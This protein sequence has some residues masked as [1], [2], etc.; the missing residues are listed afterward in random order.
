MGQL[1]WPS[2]CKIR[3]LRMVCDA[4]KPISNILNGLPDLETLTLNEESEGINRTSHVIEV[5]SALYPRLTS[6]TISYKH[7]ILNL[8][9]ARLLFSHA[10]SLVYLKITGADKSLIDRSQWEKLIKT[11]LPHLKRFDFQRISRANSPATLETVL[12]QEIASF[13]TPFWIE[14]KRWLVICTWHSSSRSIEIYTPL[15]SSPDYLPFQ[16]LRAMTTTNFA[17][18]DQ[19]YTECLSIQH[20]QIDGDLSPNVGELSV[21]FDHWNLSGWW[22]DIDRS[23]VSAQT[24]SQHWFT[25]VHSSINWLHEHTIGQTNL[26]HSRPFC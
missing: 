23:E 8:N 11:K 7:H 21:A 19:Y 13:R 14:E 15:V 6:L 10:L 1:K 12:N 25:G 9:R 16:H 2:Q 5:F 22:D 17:G 18:Q 26:P 4:G 3:H 20:R 24:S